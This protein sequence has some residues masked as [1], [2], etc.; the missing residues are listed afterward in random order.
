[1]SQNQDD[2]SSK[3]EEPTEK[4][5]RDAKKK[6]DV[7]ISKEAST[8]L[9]YAGLLAIVAFMLPSEST[10]LVTQLGGVFS[11]A[12][13]LA[14]Q[15]GG[16]G[17]SDIYAGMRDAIW[18][19][20]FFLFKCLS[21]L[22]LAAMIAGFLQGPFVVSK[23]RITPKP[24]KISPLKG[25]KKIFGKDNLVEFLKNT[26]KLVVVGGVSLWLVYEL[27]D[28]FL[29]GSILIPETIPGLVQSKV[30]QILLWVGGMMVPV[31]IFDFIWKRASHK[32]KQMMSTKE[33]RDEH[34]NTEGDPL[35]KSKRAQ[36]RRER[37]Q[38]RIAVVVPSSTLILT[39]PTH[40]A[41]ALRYER[42]LDSAPI[43]VAKG[44]DLQA[45][46]IREIAH[47]HEIP[48][49]ENKPLARALY[50]TV[51]VD[52]VIPEA[53]WPAIAELVGFV[54]DLRKKI[55]RKMPE[56]SSLRED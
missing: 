38:Q 11:R 27:M 44:A 34:K 43:C 26:V 30:I 31:A 56:G 1:M 35:I 6:G 52:E 22:V 39:N 5:I 19:A 55:R 36:I 8:F 37:A 48:V 13:Q 14:V 10:K 32:K 40:Y 3:N 24:N 53:H 46:R 45:H 7:P 21:V 41:V 25:A 16:V 17:I 29:P 23:E 28:D 47:E 49:I 2:D 20:V 54:F 42:G 15:E 18:A 9:A 51:E 4:K 12:P 50:A 33:I